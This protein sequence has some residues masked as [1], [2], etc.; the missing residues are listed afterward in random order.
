[1]NLRPSI[2]GPETNVAIFA[3]LLNLVWEFAQVP[4]FA[5]MPSADHWPRCARG[6]DSV[7]NERT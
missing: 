3:F 7:E 6:T 5:G 1:M 4:F 2:D